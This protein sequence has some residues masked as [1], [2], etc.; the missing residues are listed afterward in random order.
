MRCPRCKTFVPFGESVTDGLSVVLK[1]AALAL[2]GTLVRPCGRCGTPL[3]AAP[4]DDAGEAPIPP[5]GDGPDPAVNE[6]AGLV[7]E[8]HSAIVPT[9]RS[10]TTDQDG[11][12]LPPWRRRSYLGAAATARVRMEVRDAGGAV[13]RNAT[14]DVVVGVERPGA[15]F[16]P[17]TEGAGT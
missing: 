12:A 7:L 11:H 14:Q 16:K 5:F 2:A 8:S 13:V 6:S 4:L 15:D 3:A 10:V 1:D 9:M 17:I